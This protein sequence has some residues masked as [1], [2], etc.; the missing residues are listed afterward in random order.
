MLTMVKGFGYYIR[1]MFIPYPLNVEY[2]F[3]VKYAVDAEVLIYGCLLAGVIYLGFRL[4]RSHAMASF[5]IFLFFLSLAP[6]SNLLPMKAIINERF[7]YLSVAG[8][9]MVIGQIAVW[10]TTVNEKSLWR[11]IFSA[12]LICL[13]IYYGVITINRN[14]TWKD[15]YTFTVANLNNSPQSAV[16]HFG[17]GTAYSSRGEFA[18]AAEEFEMSLRIDPQ[19][20]AMLDEIE[21][22]AGK[23]V[24]REKLLARY[25]ESTQKRVDLF[26]GLSNLGVA[27]FNKE[28]YALSAKILEKA[29]ELKPSDLENQNNQACAYAYAGNLKKAIKICKYILSVRPDML[30]TRYNLGLFY[31][32]AGMPQEAKKQYQMV[33]E[34]DPNN[35]EAKTALEKLP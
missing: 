21:G 27:Y 3:H 23:R 4:I 34:A 12:G 16:M 15:Q 20:A 35:E 5:G 25:R 19:Y 8:F 22:M 7:L 17:M 18:L 32:A 9:G 14:L 33:L 29:A 1:L 11:K 28:D 2:L 6:V 30:K 10:L 13:I 31:G 26:E 24:G